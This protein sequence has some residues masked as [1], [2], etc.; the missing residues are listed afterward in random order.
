MQDRYPGH[1]RIRMEDDTL[2]D[3]AGAANP[4]EISLADGLGSVIDRALE[5]HPPEDTFVYGIH[6]AI[7]PAMVERL[8][9]R[10]LAAGWRHVTLRAGETGTY[11][12]VLR[13]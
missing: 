5:H 12:L 4:I 13:R 11:L 9:A 6:Q 2:G 7:S 8:R 3:A 10:Y 1:V